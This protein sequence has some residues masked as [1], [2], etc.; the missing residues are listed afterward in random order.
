[1]QIPLYL[2]RA[3]HQAL[4]HALEFPEQEVCGI[5]VDGELIRGENVVEGTMELPDGTLRDRTPATDFLLDNVTFALWE[6]AIAEWKQVVVYHSHVGLGDDDFSASDVDNIRS[7]NCPWLLV[8]TPSQKLQYF[9]PT[10]NQPYED[11][12]WHWAYSNCYTLVRDWLKWEMGF[13]LYAPTLQRDNAWEDDPN[14]NEMVIGGDRQLDRIPRD[15]SLLKRG[16]VLIMMIGQTINPN[17][18]A[19]VISP[20]RNEILHHMTNQLSGVKTLTP[21]YRKAVYQIY[22]VPRS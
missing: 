7:T 11:R 19:V 9:D 15:F 21:A 12:E 14:W 2:K 22:R 13:D 3:S 6:A 18:V 20:E 8:H 1:M 10:I 16:D 4:A 17:H 5:I